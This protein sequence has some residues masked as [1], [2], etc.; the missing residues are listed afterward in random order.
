ML[1]YGSFQLCVIGK[2][3][4]FTIFEFVIFHRRLK[5]SPRFP[6]YYPEDYEENPLP[7]EEY[8]PDVFN[9]SDPTIM[10]EEEKVVAKKK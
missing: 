5:E 4:I 9:F 8:H 7:E 6:T 1:Y 3:D 10:F 2:V